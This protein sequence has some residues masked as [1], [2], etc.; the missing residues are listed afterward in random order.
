MK[1]QQDLSRQN[2]KESANS[3]YISKETTS[4]GNDKGLTMRPS[5]KATSSFTGNGQQNNSR[6][7]TVLQIGNWPSTNSPVNLEQIFCIKFTDQFKSEIKGQ[8][9][10]IQNKI[11]D[12]K[13]SIQADLHLLETNVNQK[14]ISFSEFGKFDTEGSP[15]TVNV[16]L[17]THEVHANSSFD[18]DESWHDEEPV[19]AVKTP[20]RRGRPPKIRKEVHVVAVVAKRPYKKKEHKRGR[21]PKVVTP[22]IA[23]VA[24]FAEL[25]EPVSVSAKDNCVISQTDFNNQSKITKPQF[26]VQ[27]GVSEND[28]SSKLKT[29]SKI[30][31]EEER[32]SERGSLREKSQS[33]DR[34]VSDEE[35]ESCSENDFKQ[36]E[37][38]PEEA[39]ID[40]FQE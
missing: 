37:G 20:G 15:I 23:M 21:K 39:N 27:F 13:N 3:A 2:L 18:N 11:T 35:K 10:L 24:N 40:D 33:G 29:E 28:T 34:Q 9:E 17:Q 25:D 30:E 36:E 22:T 6:K 26:A 12:F 14:I 5:G 1:A 16:P 19:P 7:G 32:D 38:I 31:K 4:R 8:V